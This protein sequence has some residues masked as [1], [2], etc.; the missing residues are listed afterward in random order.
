MLPSRLTLATPNVV[1]A[2][3]NQL[4]ED[5]ASADRPLAPP[6]TEL[7]STFSKMPRECVSTLKFEKDYM[8]KELG[9]PGGARGK[10]PACQCRSHK[11]GGFDPWVRKI[12]WRR[13]WQPTPVFLLENPTERGTWQAT[14][15][16]V[17]KSWIQLKQLRTDAL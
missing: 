7:G 9:F 6:D 8:C 14:V 4:P 17:A 2:F 10:E 15:H 3:L 12:P 1:P 5:A 13:A 11:G 16:R